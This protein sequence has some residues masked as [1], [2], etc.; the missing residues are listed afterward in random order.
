MTRLRTPSRPPPSKLEEATVRAIYR[1]F[2]GGAVLTVAALAALLIVSGGWQP[3][4]AAVA[5][6]G[7]LVFGLSFIALAAAGE[8][9]RST[10]PS[11]AARAAG[12]DI[13]RM[14]DARGPVVVSLRTAL[15]DAAPG[16]SDSRGYS[17]GGSEKSR[18]RPD[19]ND[20]LQHQYSG[21]AHLGR[22]G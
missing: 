3:V 16:V 12:L 18:R 10:R 1:T 2:L 21:H 5:I 6:L 20:A 13:P 4:G 19:D 22:R 7:G 9:P 8:R 11:W 14:L 17:D 15:S